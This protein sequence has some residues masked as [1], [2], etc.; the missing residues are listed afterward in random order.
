MNGIPLMPTTERKARLLIKS[1]KAMVHTKVP[2]T[3]QLNYKTG[4]ATQPI[5]L[6]IDTG[7]SHIGVATVSF[8]KTKYKAE[9]SLRSSMEKKKL[10]KA[11]Q[12]ARRSRRHRKTRYRHPKFKFHTKRIYVEDPK[13]KKKQHWQKQPN[14]IMT[15]RHEGWLPPSIQSKID[16]HIAWIKRYLERL[17]QNTKLMIEVARFDIQHMMNPEIHNEMYQQGRMYEYENV[18]AYVLAKFS[19]KCPICGHKFDKQHKPR[20]H[21]VTYRSKGATDN[22]DELAP[23]CN[24]CHT[25]VEHNESGELDKLRK[26]CKRKEYREPTFMNILRKR[27]FKAFPFAEFTYGNV[28]NADRKSLGLS[29][30]H[31]NDAV[32]IAAGLEYSKIEDRQETIYIQQVRKKKRSL[33]EQT[34]RKGKKEPN[35]EAKRN[36]KN[37]PSF[38]GFS[39]Y[40]KVRYGKQDGWIT[41]FSTSSGSAYVSDKHG[42]PI[43]QPG[44]DYAL[45]SLSEL[46][47]IK[48][49]N[50]WISGLL[51]PL[52]KQ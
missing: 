42:K 48:H 37:T 36:N 39:V 11:R 16:H 49:N 40:D 51:S 5:T 44:R 30:T 7:E 23:V 2:F 18:K 9:I 13:K 38:K 43:K 32:A 3:I 8:G 26:A 41:G 20:M 34:A 19:Y 1:G 47:L 14:K 17:P 33:H 52:G 45:V 29:K 22:P 27:L 35:R 28:T 46:E 25:A 24:Q 21:H 15:N 10:I 31:A 6:G 50:S 12:E 4:T